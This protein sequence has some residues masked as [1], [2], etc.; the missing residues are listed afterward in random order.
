MAKFHIRLKVTGLEMEI[1]GERQDI[2]AL[3]GAVEKQFAGLVLPAEVVTDAGAKSLTDGRNNNGSGSGQDE[4][5]RKRRPARRAVQRG[6]DGAAAASIEF[7]HDGAKYGNPV[8][9]WSVTEKLIW[10]LY[11]L[12][13]SG[14]VKEAAGPQL[15]ATFNNYFKQAGKIHP[16]HV[17]THLGRAKMQNPPPVG[18]DRDN[19]FLTDEGDKQAEALIKAV[20]N[21]A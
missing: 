2:P 20:L 18:Q 11:V 7:R 21:P 15:A 16:P 14:D 1:D 17:T 6:S 19:Y 8:Q 3:A 5:N 12:K 4:E 9:T 10:L 13:K